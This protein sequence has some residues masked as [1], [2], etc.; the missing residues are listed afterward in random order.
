MRYLW[1]LSG[2][3]ALSA[4][5]HFHADKAVVTEQV[6]ADAE[7]AQENVGNQAT[8]IANT[9][10]D[11][12]KETGEKLREWWLTPLPAARPNRAIKTSY[13]Y[14]ALQDVLCYRQ[15]MPGWEHRLVGYQGTNAPPPPPAMMEPLP[16]RSAEASK[17]ANRLAKAE[18][19]FTEIPLNLKDA[20]KKNS[21]DPSISD[22]THETLPNPALSPQL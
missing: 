11:N 13:C 16:V 20:Q 5:D 8:R 4:C 18:P 17:P 1:L 15:P 7:Q 14:R 22:P 3:L 21:A 2:A 6:Q 12:L 10:R 19:V 9:V